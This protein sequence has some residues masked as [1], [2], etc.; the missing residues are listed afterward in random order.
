MFPSERHAQVLNELGQDLARR[1]PLQQGEWVRVRPSLREDRRIRQVLHDVVR[2]WQ[3]QPTPDTPEHQQA[4]WA[5]A[6]LA[7]EIQP[8]EW[9]ELRG[10]RDAR[11]RECAQRAG[12]LRVRGG[13]D[14]DLGDRGVH[15]VSV[16]AAP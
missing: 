10:S 9:P 6:A 14:H 13:G 7:V 3:R 1:A 2:G 5:Q 15:T 12:V 4:C 16:G 8:D 11:F